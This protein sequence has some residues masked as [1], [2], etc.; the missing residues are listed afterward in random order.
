MPKLFVTLMFEHNYRLWILSIIDVNM[1]QGISLRL[2]F[3]NIAFLFVVYGGCP[4]FAT[5]FAGKGLSLRGICRVKA[6]EISRKWGNGKKNGSSLICPQSIHAFHRSDEK[7][8]IQVW[9]DIQRD[10]DRWWKW[11]RFQIYPLIGWFAHLNW[12]CKISQLVTLLCEDP[13]NL[14]SESAKSIMQH[15][16]GQWTQRNP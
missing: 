2:Q 10:V 13:K 16:G 12:Y 9:E 6:A 15:T 4:F 11:Y 3:S 7:V 5:A 14:L 1:L 8:S